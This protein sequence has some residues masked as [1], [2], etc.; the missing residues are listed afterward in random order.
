MSGC[1]PKT[2]HQPIH[3]WTLR[4]CWIKSWQKL[5]LTE[6]AHRCP[7][8]FSNRGRGPNKSFP[9]W[10]VG[11]PEKT[12][13]PYFFSPNVG[14]EFS[15]SQKGSQSQNCQVNPLFTRFQKKLQK[16]G[17]TLALGFVSIKSI[18]ESLAYNGCFLKWWYP[19]KNT[20]SHDHF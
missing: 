6:A 14:G 8:F 12:T 4:C 16:N 9:I 7:V 13:E 5:P 20:P 2:S 17:G 1:T 3:K 19:K 10:K 18:E 15:P 11:S